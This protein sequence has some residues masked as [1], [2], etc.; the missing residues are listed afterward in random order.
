MKKWTYILIVFTLLLSLFLGG[1]SFNSIQERKQLQSNMV[2][3]FT[4]E[5]HLLTFGVKAI[6][7]LEGGWDGKHKEIHEAMLKYLYNLDVLARHAS[8]VNTDYFL[9]TISALK[10]GPQLIFESFKDDWEEIYKKLKE[11]QNM[12]RTEFNEIINQFDDLNGKF[13]DML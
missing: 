4:N 13:N 5:L 6:S 10:L 9:D 7:K 1:V 8:D 12:N 11:N 2:T 3:H